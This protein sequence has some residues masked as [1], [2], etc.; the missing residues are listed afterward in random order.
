MRS[1]QT[2]RFKPLLCDADLVV[3]VS[4]F[5]LERRSGSELGLSQL[6]P[7]FFNLRCRCSNTSLLFLEA[8]HEL[9]HLM[10]LAE[11]ALEPSFWATILQGGDHGNL[12]GCAKHRHQLT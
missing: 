3:F 2:D 7:N 9:G 4:L 12:P 5:G 6:G 11:I 8:L 10:T 1:F